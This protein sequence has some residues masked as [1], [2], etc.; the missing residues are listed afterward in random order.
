MSV[1][2]RF[3]PIEEAGALDASDLEL[4]E[5]IRSLLV[6]HGKQERFGL[7]LLHKH[8]NLEEDEV[9]LESTDATK[10][11]MKIAAVPVRATTPADIPTNWYLAQG[12]PVPL[13]KCRSSWHVD[14]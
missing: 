6:K 3:K 7:C 11:E 10:R 13:T 5:E 4:F 2:N 1:A 8:F 12:T 9:L 14:N